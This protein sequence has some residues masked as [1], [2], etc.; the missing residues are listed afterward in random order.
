MPP[1][2]SLTHDVPGPLLDFPAY[3][4]LTVVPMFAQEYL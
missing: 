4:Y 3:Y 1:P 2:G